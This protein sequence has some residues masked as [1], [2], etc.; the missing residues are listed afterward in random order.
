LRKRQGD[1][2]PRLLAMIAEEKRAMAEAE[3]RTIDAKAVP[4]TRG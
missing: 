3:E 1:V 2:L 4:S